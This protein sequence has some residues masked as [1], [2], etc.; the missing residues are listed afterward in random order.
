MDKERLLAVSALNIAEKVNQMD[1]GQLQAYVDA[2]NSFVDGFPAQEKKL[3]AALEAKDHTSFLDNLAVVY[4]SLKKIRADALAEE[5]F[6]Q[7]DVLKTLEHEAVAAWAIYFLGNLN[8]LCIDIQMAEY[9]EEVKNEEKV[10]NE[11]KK[12]ETGEIPR[13]PRTGEKT[14]LAVD[15]AAFFLSM[16]KQYVSGTGHK[17]VCVNSGNAA[18]QYLAARDPDLFILDIE[19]PE[20]DGYEL[21]RRIREKGKKA[22]I[23]FLTGN[24]RRD[25]VLK[26]IKVGASDFIIKPITQAQVLERI[27]KFI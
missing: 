20:M 5:C 12:E 21:A 26:A 4:V 24:V 6:E 2:L 10:G 27:A 15:D 1:D 9:K 3:L 17:L 7:M 22:P 16:L 25:N 18:L 13:V 8:T 14:I 19:M 23:I 11:E